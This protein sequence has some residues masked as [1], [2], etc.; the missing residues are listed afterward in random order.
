MHLLVTRPQ[1]EAERTARTLRVLGHDALVAPLL[2]IETLPGFNPD[3]SFWPLILMTSGNAARAIEDNP[4][5]NALLDI[6]VLAVGRQ[7]EAAARAAGF[8]NVTSADGNA[9]DLARIVRMAAR[10]KSGT[11]LYLAGSDRARDLPGEL[12]ACGIQVETVVV[13]RAE[14][15]VHL[16]E[17]ARDAA[18]S[19]SIDGVLHYSRRTAEIFLQCIV[20]EPLMKALLPAVQY[21]LS[22]RVAGP[23]RDAGFPDV[24]V[25]SGPHE[26]AMLDLIASAHPV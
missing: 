24:R 17:K 14:A 6:P 4:R 15:V 25:A 11:L 12:G 18:L 2:R 13:Y 1:A 10:G 22:Q 7:T 3:A 16:P 26:K 8:V 9:G 21:C 23:L 5:K 19:G 20:E